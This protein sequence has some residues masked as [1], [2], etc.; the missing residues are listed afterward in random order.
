[1]PA[2]VVDVDDVSSLTEGGFSV[3]TL[4]L[5]EV[6]TQEETGFANFLGELFGFALF[7]VICLVSL[8]GFYG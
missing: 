6:L 3:G 8:F 1:M 5:A 2:F 4:Q 7:G